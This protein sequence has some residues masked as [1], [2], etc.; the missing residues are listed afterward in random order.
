MVVS[1]V[2]SPPPREVFSLYQLSRSVLTSSNCVALEVLAFVGVLCGA[3]CLYVLSELSSY[4]EVSR[5]G[6]HMWALEPD[7]V[8]Q[9]TLATPSVARAIESQQYQ[10]VVEVSQEDDL[11]RTSVDLRHHVGLCPVFNRCQKL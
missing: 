8:G 5:T 2:V 3:E 11:P 7:S 1:H 9:L 6:L 10:T 4:D